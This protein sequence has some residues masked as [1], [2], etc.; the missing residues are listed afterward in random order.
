MSM[1]FPVQALAQDNFSNIINTN[2]SNWNYTTIGKG[3]NVLQAMKRIGLS[4]K[5]FNYLLNNTVFAINMLD[6]KYDEKLSSHFSNQ[7]ESL[8][9]IYDREGPTSILFEKKGSKYESKVISDKTRPSVRVNNAKV[10]TTV[11]EAGEENG[12]DKDVLKDFVEIFGARMNFS[13]DTFSGDTF[14]IAYVPDT[15]SGQPKILGAN[16]KNKN[17]ELSAYLYQLNN[18]S[19]G[20]FDNNGK[21]YLSDFLDAPLTYKYVSSKFNPLRKHPISKHITPHRGVD[22]AAPLGTPVFS[23][24]DGLVLEAAKTYANGNYVVIQHSLGI[25]TKYLHLSKISVA[26]GEKV[27]KGNE[28]GAVGN[29]GLSTAP[30]LHYEFLI[31][32]KHY[33]PLKVSKKHEYSKNI[34]A[35]KLKQFS[36]SIESTKKLIKSSLFEKA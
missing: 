16:Y 15:P 31:D 28:I 25:Q 22:F 30:H 6:V 4:S 3:E 2:K 35:S 26:P 32:G 9:L 24:S 23:A 8:M 5:F 34:P 13:T 20:Y 12:I 1:I 11:F 27:L 21:G 36:L 18:G 10:K 29:T 17:R 19:W 7:N 14:T 33:D